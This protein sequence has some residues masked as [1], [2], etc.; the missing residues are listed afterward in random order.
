MMRLTHFRSSGSCNGDIE[1][2][3]PFPC[4]N[5]DHIILDHMSEHYWP[6][7]VYSGTSYV[8]ASRA[9]LLS[10]VGVPGT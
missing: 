2:M 7:S 3:Y 5:V 4:D 10:N 1:G 6:I 8:A 9:E